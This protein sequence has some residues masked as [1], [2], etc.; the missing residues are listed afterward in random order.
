MLQSRLAF[1]LFGLAVIVSCGQPRPVASA[2]TPSLHGPSPHATPSMTEPVV[3]SPA[4][5]ARTAP[6]PTPPPAPSVQCQSGVTPSTMAIVWGPDR[7]Y[8]YDV[9]DPLHPKAVCKIAHTSARFLTGLSFEYLVPQPNGTTNVVLHSLGSNQE[10]VAATFKAN[11]LGAYEGASWALSWQAGL[12]VVAYSTPGSDPN[13]NVTDVWT[14][15]TRSVT[16]IYS[17]SVPGLDAFSR[18]G[19]PPPVLAISP[20]GQYLATGWV[21][22][23]KIHVFRLSDNADV[24]SE[25]PSDLWSAVWSERGHSLYFVGR[26]SVSAWTPESGM[27]TV[28]NTVGWVL[29]PNFAPDGSQVA[30]TAVS[31]NHDIRAYVYDFGAKSS[32]LLVDKPRSSAMFVKSGWVWMLEEAA[33]QPGP[34]QN[35]FDPTIADGK[36]LAMDLTAGSE[37][38]VMIAAKE[39][40]LEP[41][42]G[43]YM[44]LV[45]LWPKT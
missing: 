43:L 29:Q 25:L 41:P 23:N 15:T 32:R 27:T 4:S 13:A 2:T 30:F 7:Q 12:N 11:V 35:C 42:Y 8:I 6:E 38:E 16:K 9:G 18:P 24:T 14:A 44:Q 34:N 21:I 17:Y 39:S 19:L 10:S 33:C 37:S 1:A 40:P 28:Q 36:I 20:D 45:D 26:N 22:Q 3:P 31:A 5:S